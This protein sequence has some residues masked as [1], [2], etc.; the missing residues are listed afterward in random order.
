MHT[1]SLHISSWRIYSVHASDPDA[2][3]Q[4]T[5]HASVPY[6]HAQHALK[7]P[8]QIWNFYAYAEHAS[9][10]LMR[11]LRVR[12]SSWLVC[13]ATAS[14]PD[15]YTQGKHQFLVHMISIF[16]GSAFCAHISTW[17]TCLVHAPVPDLY[18][19]RT[20]QFLTRML[21]VR[22]SSWCACSACASISYAHAEDIQNGIW[23]IGKLMH[24][25][26]MRIRNWCICSGCTSVPDAH[27][28]SA[29]Q[30]LTHMLSVRIKVGAC[31]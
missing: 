13:S 5:H 17:R 15:P 14:V 11:M 30:S 4:N 20:H 1:L 10:K 6:V 25:L 8:F 19:Q 16:E 9:K 28:Q 7:G 2:H 12:I 31:T 26:S 22:I 3:D 21:S 24:M 29:H 23:K 27:A 18:A